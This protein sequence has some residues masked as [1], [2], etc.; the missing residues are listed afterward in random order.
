MFP[1]PD[2]RRAHN[3]LRWIGRTRKMRGTSGNSFNGSYRVHGEGDTK[4]GCNHKVI[5][6]FFGNFFLF[7]LS[8][9]NFDTDNVTTAAQGAGNLFCVGIQEQ[10][11]QDSQ[12]PQRKYKFMLCKWQIFETLLQDWTR[13]K[14]CP[15]QLGTLW[16]PVF[17]RDRQRVC[18]PIALQHPSLHS[19]A[20]QRGTKSC[21]MLLQFA[22]TMSLWAQEEV[23]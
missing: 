17:P 19:K 9:G 16:E 1:F 4:L 18:E 15:V 14:S 22:F 8:A 12:N 10:M 20:E 2:A 3:R 13:K 23:Q 21:K 5:C 7:F 11:F 6:S